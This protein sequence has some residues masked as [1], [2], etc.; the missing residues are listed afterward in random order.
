MGSEAEQILAEKVR[1]LE[2][3][4]RE[5]EASVQMLRDIEE[6]KQLKARYVRHIDAQDWQAWAD[7]V[8]TED[9]RHESVGEV[10]EGRD[11]AIESISKA[12]AGGVATHQCHTP[13]I[14]ITDADHATGIW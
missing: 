10:Y 2:A 13:E 7:E 12:M 3:Q 11:H 5:L 8:I 1:A 4:V 14:T 6:I 9:F